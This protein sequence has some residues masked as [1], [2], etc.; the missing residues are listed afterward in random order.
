M[1]TRR[2]RWSI[3][4]MPTLLC[5]SRGPDRLDSIAVENASRRVGY[6]RLSAFADTAVDAAAD[7][8]APD[9]GNRGPP[10]GGRGRGGGGGQSTAMGAPAPLIVKSISCAS[11]T[12]PPAK[13][14]GSR[15]PAQPKTP[16]ASLS[17]ACR[18]QG[19]SRGFGAGRGVGTVGVEAGVSERH[20]HLQ[21]RDCTRKIQQPLSRHL[22]NDEQNFHILR[23]SRR[24]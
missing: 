24:T 21:D 17:D 13:M 23:N 6:R 16:T 15:C 19:T 18:A 7:A 14:N 9:S 8:A 2:C 20:D 1:T 12:S 4:G 11:A 5:P 10:S 3:G 22:R